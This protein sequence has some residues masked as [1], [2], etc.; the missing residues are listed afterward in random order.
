M[1]PMRTLSKM[2]QFSSCCRANSRMWPAQLS[3]LFI[4][5]GCVSFLFWMLHS[6]SV[7]IIF[8]LPPTTSWVHDKGAWNVNVP[9]WQSQNIHQRKEIS[10]NGCSVLIMF[11]R[12][13]FKGFSVTFK[14]LR[15][16][17]RLSADNLQTV[18]QLKITCQGGK[19]LP[20]CL[21]MKTKLINNSQFFNQL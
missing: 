16:F 15:C 3:F 11:F 19:Q 12:D 14:I 13:E 9:T 4:F 8:T 6:L 1:D 17:C 7:N 5:Q 18:S 20:E 10:Q 2:L 21:I